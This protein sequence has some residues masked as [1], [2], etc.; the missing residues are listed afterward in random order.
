LTG[1]IIRTEDPRVVV[2]VL[3]RRPNLHNTN[4]CF[5]LNNQAVTPAVSSPFLIKNPLSLATMVNQ[6]PAQKFFAKKASTGRT[7]LLLLLLFLLLL[8]TPP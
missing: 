1:A 6:I 2:G 5:L 7:T 4:C 3:G 8:F